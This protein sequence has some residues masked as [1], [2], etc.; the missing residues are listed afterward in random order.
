MPVN[1]VPPSQPPKPPQRTVRTAGGAV[2]IACSAG[3][4]A[5]LGT[6][7]SGGAEPVLT[8]YAD[9]LAQGLPTVCHG[10]TRHVTTTPIIVG[11]K[12]TK[13]QCAREESDALYK[14]QTRLAQCFKRAD[15]PQSVFE[16]A[17]SHAWNS[18]APNTCGSLAMQSFNAG[19]W[20]EGCR[21][22]SLSDAGRPVWSSVRTGKMLPNGQ[23]EFKFVQG[24]ANRRAAETTY[25]GK[26]L[27]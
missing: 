22:L 6:W 25:C 5:F 27:K 9:K 15:V 12:W 23:P 19:R 21:R 26:D 4:M 10:L 16:G 17:S 3:L 7:E 24:L 8:V 2:L 18:G 1:A 11:Q 20:A 14:V 13:E